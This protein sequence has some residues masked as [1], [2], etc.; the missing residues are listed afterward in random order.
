MNVLEKLKKLTNREYRDAYM[1]SHVRTGI[2]YQIQALRKKFGFSQSKLGKVVDKPQSVISR[3]E[4]EEYEGVSVQSL[5]DI[6]RGL[7]VALLV[8][9]VSYPEFLTYASKTSEIELQPDTVSESFRKLEQKQVE[10]QNALFLNS[11]PNIERSRRS[12][13]SNGRQSAATRDSIDIAQRKA[14]HLFSQKKQL[15]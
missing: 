3:L 2:A 8:R 6:A 13:S 9:F 14:P 12:L 11:P 7:D 10:K 5:L 15:V 1:Q 4:N